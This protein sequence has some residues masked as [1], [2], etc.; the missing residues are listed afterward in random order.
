MKEQRKEQYLASKA[1]YAAAI[2]QE[3]SKSWK[4]FCNVTSTI[5]SWNAIYKMAAGKTKRAA[6]IT[7][8]RQ[9]DGLLTTNLQGTL[10][11]MI[12]KSAPDDNQEDDTDTHRQ[13]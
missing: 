6:H 3:K 5:N 13:I 11:Q 8:L 12:P 9:Q 10:L 4:E 2:R 7:T 1:E